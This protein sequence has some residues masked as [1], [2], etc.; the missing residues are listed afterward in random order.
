MG[1]VGIV[2]TRFSSNATC[3][4]SAGVGDGIRNAWQVAAGS[5]GARAK[6]EGRQSP[7]KVAPQ[8]DLPTRC[9]GRLRGP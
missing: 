6:S 7:V 3:V 8:R 4:W 1:G 2:T 9:P 5:P